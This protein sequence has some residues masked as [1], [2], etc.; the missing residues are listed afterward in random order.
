[1]KK[2]AVRGFKPCTVFYSGNP[3]KGDEMDRECRTRGTCGKCAQN[4]GLKNGRERVR[5][6]I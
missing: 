4:V 1:M 5:W 6:K 2:F 3:M